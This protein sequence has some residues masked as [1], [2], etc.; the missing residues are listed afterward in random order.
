MVALWHHN[1]GV[2]RELSQRQIVP[3]AAMCYIILLCLSRIY[4]HL[5]CFDFNETLLICSAFIFLSCKMQQ[6][7]MGMN[8]KIKDES[9]V[10]M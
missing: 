10:A 4:G 6:I 9:A 1:T 3:E 2:S 5:S 8:G 7:Y